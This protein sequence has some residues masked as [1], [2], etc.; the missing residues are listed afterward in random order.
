MLKKVLIPALA[1]AL[2]LAWSPL[3]SAQNKLNPTKEKPIVWKAQTLWGAA[4]IPQKSFEVLCENIKQMSGGRL[5]VEPYAAGV[6]VPTNETLTALTNNILQV[7]HVWPG[8]GGGKEPALI[9]IS[10]LIYAY[11]TP[12][13]GYM[14]YYKKGGEEIFKEIY[15]PFKAIPVGLMYW[16]SES[17]PSRV[18]IRNKADFKGLKIRLPQGMENDLLTR[19]GATAIQFPGTEIFSALDKGVVDAANWSSLGVNESLGLHDIPGIAYATYPGF[20][21]MP[22][23][24]FTVNTDRWNELPEDLQAIVRVACKAW[25]LDSWMDIHDADMAAV[26]KYSQPGSKIEIVSW[27]DA[28]RKDMFTEAYNTVWQDWKKKS[29]LAKKAIESYEAYLKEL[30]RLPITETSPAYTAY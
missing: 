23:G 3:A 1:L 9:P 2:T 14:W 26:K 22:I 13:E 5:I 4:E 25:G 20:H 30:G 19:L 15:A 6:I 27:T 17:Y 11:N 29:P 28:D 8:Y 10:D 21:S 12:L 24:D 16:T 18:P 7:L